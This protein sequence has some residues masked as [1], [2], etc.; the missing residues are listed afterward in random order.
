MVMVCRVRMAKFL[1]TQD[2]L[3]HFTLTDKTG[4]LLVKVP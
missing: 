4:K 3:P 1:V 2:G